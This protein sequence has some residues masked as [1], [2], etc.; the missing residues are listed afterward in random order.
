MDFH[1]AAETAIDVVAEHFTQKATSRA[2]DVVDVAVDRL[3]DLV[4]AKLNGTPSGRRRLQELQSRPDDDIARRKAAEVLRDEAGEDKHFANALLTSIRTVDNRH[5]VTKSRSATSYGRL[6]NNGQKAAA[7]QGTGNITN[8]GRLKQSSRTFH[9]GTIRFGMGGLISGV[10]VL[11]TVATGG[12]AAVVASQGSP[13]NAVLADAVGQWHNGGAMVPVG[14]G[15]QL[16]FQDANLTVDSSGK[17]VLRATLVQGGESNTISCRGRLREDG[18]QLAV[19]VT[20]GLCSSTSATVAK[21]KQTFTAQ[22]W[23][24]GQQ[25]SFQRQ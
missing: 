12:T 9:I 2:N 8:T 3:A 1:D 20:D 25:M 5:T 14:G 23:V 24:N 7:S 21:D 4:T 19:E 16:G 13:P 6:T 11:I 17:F 15:E 22:K 18:P 10:A